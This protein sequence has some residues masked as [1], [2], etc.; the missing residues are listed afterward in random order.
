MRSSYC[1]YAVAP[2]SSVR[3]WDVK[4]RHPLLST[5][6][7]IFGYDHHDPLRFSS[8]CRACRLRMEGHTGLTPPLTFHRYL[9]YL[10]A[11]YVRAVA[12]AGGRLF[13]A[14]DDKTVRFCYSSNFF[15]RISNIF[16]LRSG[17]GK[18]FITIAFAC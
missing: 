4:H 5:L 12:Y 17:C 11:D 10:C 15:E 3:L 8:L 6:R 7:F 16:R 13:S 2:D 9:S 1:S 14:G 18:L